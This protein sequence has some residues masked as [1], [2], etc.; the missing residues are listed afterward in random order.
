[1]LP[2]Q[3]KTPHE[4]LLDK[5]ARLANKRGE[6]SAAAQALKDLITAEDTTPQKPNKAYEQK[7]DKEN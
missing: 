7:K 3:N 2:L 5:L 6:N 1:M 4:R